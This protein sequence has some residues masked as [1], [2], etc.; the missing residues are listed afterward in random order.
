CTDEHERG[1]AAGERRGRH[2]IEE[3]CA[4]RHTLVPPTAPPPERCAPEGFVEAALRRRVARR[5]LGPVERRT[6]ARHEACRDRRL[7]LLHADTLPTAHAPPDRFSI[8]GVLE[9]IGDTPL[10]RLGLLP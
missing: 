4:A 6:R 8:V 9:A 5:H 7:A 2:A 1:N 10:V 3:R